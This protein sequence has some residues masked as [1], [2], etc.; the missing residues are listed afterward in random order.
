M[1]V[2]PG[3]NLRFALAYARL[4]YRVVPLHTPIFENGSVRCSCSKP[5]C[6]RNIGKHPHT[7]NG[8]SDA[9]RDPATIRGWS[10][11]WPDANVGVLMGDRHLGLDVDPPNGEESL[12]RLE[13]QH[14]PLPDTFEVKTG[15]GRQLIF[16]APPGRKL[17][18]TRGEIA[19]GLDTRADGGYVVAPPSLHFSGVRYRPNNR[20]K[21]ATAPDWFIN[22]LMRPEVPP[23]S[24]GNAKKVRHPNRHDH[25]LKLAGSMRRRGASQESIEQA[26]LA[27]N[28]L[29]CDPPKPDEEVLKIARD[30][31]R[32]P[33]GSNTNSESW[34]AEL[35]RNEKGVPRAM[36]ANAITM[37][38]NHPHWRGVLAYNQ[39]SLF[40]VAKGL[41]PFPKEIG[42]NWTECDDIL[43]TDWMQHNGIAVGHGIVA[44][45][46]QAVAH[47]H[48]FHPIRDYFAGLTWDKTPRIGSWLVK[49][50]GAAD[51]L[52]TRAVGKCWLISAVARVLKPGCQVDHTLMVE[53][54]RV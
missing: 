34:R 15:R 47:E 42:S 54:S 39:A 16:T 35:I 41:C 31:G 22:L 12:E 26:L 43:A 33:A 27:E 5:T 53:A 32:K 29:R 3:R 14:G 40:V 23:T 25:L 44:A 1:T 36:L 49:Y 17:K 18:N 20:L 28:R 24:N 52:Y 13:A 38:R 21:L 6:D 45:A 19:P 10:R 30:I 7:K 11:K 51:S 50:L 37:L 46:V 4:G 48:R 8:L 2:S 9:S